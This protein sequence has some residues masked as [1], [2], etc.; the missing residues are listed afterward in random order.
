MNSSI[1]EVTQLVTDYENNKKKYIQ[2]YIQKCV[3]KNISLLDNDIVLFGSMNVSDTI[4]SYIETKIEKS[5]DCLL[6]TMTEQIKPLLEAYIQQKIKIQQLM[7]EKNN[8]ID[9]CDKLSV[10]QNSKI[11]NSK[12]N[13]E[14]DCDKECDCVDKCNCNKDGDDLYEDCD[15]EEDC[16]CIDCEFEEECDCE[17]GEC[18]CN[19]EYEEEE[20]DCNEEECD[21]ND[22]VNQYIKQLDTQ[23][24]KNQDEYEYCLCKICRFDSIKKILRLSLELNPCK[25]KFKSENSSICECMKCN[26]KHNRYVS[27]MSQY[28]LDNDDSMIAETIY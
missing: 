16:D 2:K 21:C 4:E 22:I 6:S 14:C 24:Q 1:Q 7:D 12:Y 27:I 18:D 26:I 17:E 15:C 13:K 10:E 25:E 11:E 23:S 5:V 3:K 9:Y 28:Y 8:L 19:F 20:C